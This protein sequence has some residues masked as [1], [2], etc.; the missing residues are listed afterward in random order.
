[1]SNG[2]SRL[3]S[4]PLPRS[5]LSIAEFPVREVLIL[6]TLVEDECGRRSE[7]GSNLLSLET[8]KKI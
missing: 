4:N 7:H 8:A 1:M 2:I 6:W 3:S 5:F